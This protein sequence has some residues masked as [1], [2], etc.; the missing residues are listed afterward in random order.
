M[1]KTILF[2][3]GGEYGDLYGQSLTISL[4]DIVPTVRVKCIGGENSESSGTDGLTTDALNRELE[5][6]KV[7][8]VILADQPSFNLPLIRQT[9][10]KGIPVIYFA[11]AYNSSIN[12]R[13]LKKLTGLIDKVLAVFPFEPP[14]YGAAGIDVEFV[15]HPLVD[16]VDCSVSR[17][18]AKATLG[19]CSTEVPIT[20]IAG[21]NTDEA[22]Q[23]LRLMVEG[24]AEAA[25]ITT[26]KVK[27][28]IPDAERYEESLLNDL[29]KIS[30]RRLG[31]FKGQR[32][33]ALR[34]SHGAV[35]VAG[36]AT[37]EAAL[38]D[39]RMLT[40][41]K[42][43]KVSYLLSRFRERNRFISLPNVILDR[44]QFPELEQKAITP[45]KITEEV[46]QLLEGGYDFTVEEMDDGLAKVR[47]ELGPPGTIKRAA[48]AICRATGS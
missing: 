3:S 37:I 5:S 11:G 21:G 24:A 18:E 4:K 29:I 33:T 43:S 34:A 22:A 13:Q 17:D 15:G 19:Y 41:H 16:I 39:T 30:P 38:S 20:F 32:A 25:E 10:K 45:N 2:I 1:G 8:C 7:D 12:S 9:K 46:G 27:L 26:R 42:T 44:M 31:S 6:E 28:I 36:T 47:E 14:L 40:L 35:V 23:L 48:E